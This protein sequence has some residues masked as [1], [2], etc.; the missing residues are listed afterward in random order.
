MKR[1][2][3]VATTKLPDYMVLLIKISFSWIF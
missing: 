2:S 1:I 3:K